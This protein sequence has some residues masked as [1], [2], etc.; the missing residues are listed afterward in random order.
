MS[1]G[2]PFRKVCKGASDKM[3]TSLVR[4]D[5]ASPRFVLTDGWREKH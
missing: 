3:S 5:V 1:D 4:P 2:R